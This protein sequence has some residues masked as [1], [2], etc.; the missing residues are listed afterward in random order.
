MKEKE[1]HFRTRPECLSVI[2]KC[3]IGNISAQQTLHP[4][5]YSILTYNQ[6][7]SFDYKEKLSFYQNTHLKPLP[8]VDGTGRGVNKT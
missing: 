7:S 6:A 4:T 5:F 8:M 2:Y 1:E 3:Y